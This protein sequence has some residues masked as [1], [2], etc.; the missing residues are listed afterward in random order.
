VSEKARIEDLALFGGQTAFDAPIHVGR[1][2]IGNR[3]RLQEKINDILDSGWLTNDGPNTREFERRMADLVGAE[4][5][6]AICNGTQALEITVRMA[7]LSGEVI[8]PSFTFIATAHALQWQQITPI[9]CDIDPQTHNIDPGQVEKRITPRT[10]GII[11]VHLWGRPCSIE[12]LDEIA[13][14]HGLKL[15]FDAAH[16]F[17]CSYKGRM[18]GNFGL[19]EIFSFHATKFFHTCEG[20]AVVTN[21]DQLA[22]EIRLARNFGFAGYDNVIRLGINGKM[23]ELSAAMGLVG[24]ESLDEFIADNRRNYTLYRRELE[25]IPGVRSL[26]YDESEKCNYQY[27]VLEMDESLTH[28]S[29][30]LLIEILHAE[31]VLARRYFYPGCHLMEPYRSTY[32]GDALPETEKIAARVISLP[33]GTSVGENEIRQICRIIRLAMENG[34]EVRRLKETAGPV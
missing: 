16:A 19:A 24:L 22:E 34:P 2:N 9:F 20:G 31:N 32:A 3:D 12:A 28:V 4:H 18:I 11:G 25:G 17:G 33:T 5:C 26:T 30:D 13:A 29:R 10:T 14:R 7:G 15:L 8:L 21:D 27:I 1:P 23:N 6:I